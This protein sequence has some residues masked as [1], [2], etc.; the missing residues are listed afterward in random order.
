MIHY[1]VKLTV[2]EGAELS[3]VISKRAQSTQT[4]PNAYILLNCDE[5]K[6]GRPVTHEQL[7]QVLRI[8]TRTIERVRKRFCQS[9][10]EVALERKPSRRTYERKVDGDVEARL[11]HLCCSEPSKGYAGWS[12]RLLA[13]RMVELSYVESLS[14]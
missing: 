1:H 11:V 14:L 6:H 8:N 5:G 4:F 3:S 2:A 7:A 9:G 12:L 13:N 10:W